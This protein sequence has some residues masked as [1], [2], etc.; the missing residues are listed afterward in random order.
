M[1]CFY[2]KMFVLLALIII[3]ISAGAQTETQIEKVKDGI[4]KVGD[5]FNIFPVNKLGNTIY[6]DNKKLVSKV[7]LIMVDLTEA[8]NGF[9]YH[10][11]NENDESILGYAGNEHAKF[12][13][14]D[15]GYYQLI[16]KEG[17]SKI[18]RINSDDVIQNLLPR[19]KTSGGLVYNNS[20]KAAFFHIARGENI[21]TEDGK[22][23]YLYTFKIHIAKINEPDVIHLPLSISDYAAKLRMIW[24][25]EETLQYSLSDGSINRIQ[26]K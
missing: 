10:A 18:Y 16:T 19:Y 25:D 6:L 24:L 11:K 23:R 20:D 5:R 15:G 12:T 8:H 7:G 22:L 21:E 13:A 3:A 9:I 1:K 14:L 2:R 17:G 4:L 26:I